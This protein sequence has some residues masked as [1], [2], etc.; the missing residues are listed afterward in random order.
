MDQLQRT[1]D[2][3]TTTIIKKKKKKNKR[4]PRDGTGHSSSAARDRGTR[5][6]GLAVCKPG[7]AVVCK[8]A[9]K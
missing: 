3:R 9:M 1:D 2:V 4:K 6:E 7:Q 5:Y 8:S